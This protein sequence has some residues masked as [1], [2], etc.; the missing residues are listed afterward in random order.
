MALVALNDS[1][2]TSAI[3]YAAALILISDGNDKLR[4][5]FK[6]AFTKAADEE[7]G[8]VFAQ[9]DPTANGQLS[10]RYDYQ[11]RSLLIGQY[12]GEVLWRAFPSLGE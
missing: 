6:T 4:S 11:G 3:N 5:D 12:G 8:I 10:Q 2:F 1:N 7:E 9:V